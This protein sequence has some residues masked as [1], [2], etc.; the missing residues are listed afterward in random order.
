MSSVPMLLK[1]TAREQRAAVLVSSSVHGLEGKRTLA[2]Q[3]CSRHSCF[4]VLERYVV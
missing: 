2:V 4:C 3:A 1:P